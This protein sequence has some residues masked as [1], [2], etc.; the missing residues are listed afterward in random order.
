[1]TAIHGHYQGH[2]LDL[3]QAHLP[4]L[5]DAKISISSAYV[6]ELT[7]FR[8]LGIS[9]IYSKKIQALKLSPV[10][11]HMRFF[12]RRDL[13]INNTLLFS[14]TPKY[15]CILFSSISSFIGC[16]LDVKRLQTLQNLKQE[17]LDMY[18]KNV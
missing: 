3:L 11:C 13:S 5:D 14:S 4:C 15:S 18:H 7:F 16:L 17:M 6:D 8:D 12:W 2:S 10:E 9:S 1:M